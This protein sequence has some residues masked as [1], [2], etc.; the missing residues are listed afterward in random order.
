MDTDYKILKPQ[1]WSHPITL[2]NL[3]THAEIQIGQKQMAIVDLLTEIGITPNL[4]EQW[5]YDIPKEIATKIAQLAL[6]MSKPKRKPTT[7]TPMPKGKIGKDV[8][9]FDAIFNL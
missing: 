7:K 1:G 5:D 9:V 8:D 6:N 2:R 4:A 3:A